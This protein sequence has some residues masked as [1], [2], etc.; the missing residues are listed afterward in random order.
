MY[1]CA[2]KEVVLS[3][4][5]QRVQSITYVDTAAGAD[6]YKLTDN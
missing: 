4:D 1:R 2:V 3:P 6:I 5:G